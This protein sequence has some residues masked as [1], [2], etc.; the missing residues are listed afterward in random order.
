MADEDSRLGWSL[1]REAV[2]SLDGQIR[3]LRSDASKQL[4]DVFANL[5]KISKTRT[6]L[7]NDIADLTSVVETYGGESLGMILSHYDN[8]LNQRLGKQYKWAGD[9]EY[10]NYMNAKNEHDANR[11][12]LALEKQ[13]LNDSL[14]ETEK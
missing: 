5:D 12:K 2:R 13:I 3:S 6:H 1:W 8:E 7:E 9:L 10:L 11:K 4:D 14:R